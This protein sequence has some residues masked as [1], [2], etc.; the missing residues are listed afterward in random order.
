M[1]NGACRWGEGKKENQR[2]VTIPR[3]TN[4]RL[5]AKGLLSQSFFFV[6]GSF[7]STCNH[8]FSHSSKQP[9]AHHSTLPQ[10][11]FAYTHFIMAPPKKSG[12]ALLREEGKLELK[13][14][15]GYFSWG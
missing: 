13:R 2:V 9:P 15:P 5:L 6:W 11:N 10:R 14:L 1:V 7:G 3:M 8:A 4:H 12:R